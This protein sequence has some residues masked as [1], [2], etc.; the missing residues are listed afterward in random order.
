LGKKYALWRNFVNTD[1]ALK[2]T[3]AM[4]R[5]I[6]ELSEVFDLNIDP[7]IKELARENLI[8]EVDFEGYNFTSEQKRMV[9]KLI[10]YNFRAIMPLETDVIMAAAN[11][12]NIKTVVVNSIIDFGDEYKNKIIYKQFSSVIPKDYSDFAKAHRDGILILPAI[13]PGYISILTS[14]FYKTIFVTASS[15][16]S[17]LVRALFP[18]YEE[19][20]LISDKQYADFPK[21]QLGL[22]NDNNKNLGFLVNIINNEC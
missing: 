17:P 1:F 22:N 3:P 7:A 9:Q 15:S 4:A 14:D 21:K 10:D 16:K 8:T 12:A 20:M 13:L 2:K 11:I 19:K 6:I 18:N 5:R